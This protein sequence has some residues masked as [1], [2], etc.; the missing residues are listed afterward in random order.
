MDCAWK[1]FHATVPLKT[2]LSRKEVEKVTWNLVNIWF[3]K[4]KEKY[5]ANLYL[6]FFHF[7]V[8][9][10][11]PFSKYSTRV[12]FK[13]PTS[14]PPSLHWDPLP[15]CRHMALIISCYQ[16]SRKTKSEGR[17]VGIVAVSAGRRG[18]RYTSKENQ[19]RRR[20]H[21]HDFLKSSF[22]N[23]TVYQEIK[24]NILASFRLS[25]CWFF[26]LILQSIWR[27]SLAAVL[28]IRI[29]FRKSVVW[30]RGSGSITKCHRSTT[31]WKIFYII[32][33]PREMYEYVYTALLLT[34]VCLIK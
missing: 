31:L 7:I 1:P 25:F 27:F 3:G 12:L 33:W 18:R 19:F 24:R 34:V 32:I 5:L 16:E 6:V 30:I 17:V 22:Y 10:L 4:P 29:Q 23:F 26:S 11:R 21:E 2:Q 9:L 20:S 14:W 15:P 28:W 13:R 8:R